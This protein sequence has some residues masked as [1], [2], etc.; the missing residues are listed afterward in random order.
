M[1]PFELMDLV[2]LDVAHA[3]MKSLYRSSSRSRFRPSFLPSQRVAAGLLGRK[4]GT[5]LLLVREG[6]NPPSPDPAL[7]AHDRYP[8]GRPVPEAA[9]LL[10]EALADADLDSAGGPTSSASSCRWARTAPPRH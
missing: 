3:V 1:G 10:A 8:S 2:G 9:E 5:R 6:G 4:T 7:P